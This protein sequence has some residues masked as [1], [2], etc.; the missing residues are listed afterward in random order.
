M[1]IQTVHKYIHYLV[2]PI[3][4]IISC[5]STKKLSKNLCSID[6]ENN[7][8]SGT[9]LNAKSFYED[10]LFL[11]AIIE[12]LTKGK[13]EPKYVEKKQFSS[14][15]LTKYAGYHIY[16]CPDTTWAKQTMVKHLIEKYHI[17]KYD[18]VY[19]DTVHRIKLFD[20]SIVKKRSI[21]DCAY[22]DIRVNRRVNEAHYISLKCYSWSRICKYILQEAGKNMDT[23]SI[24]CDTINTYC[25]FVIPVEAY[26]VGGLEGY[27]QHL[28]DS[29]GISMT[30]ERV[31]TINLSVYD[32]IG[33]PN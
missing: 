15:T 9:D 28:L 21:E 32:Y 10:V 12:Q 23:N 30:L 6:Y 27:K 25:D 14:K 17:L 11:P 3:L 24:V 18:S 20:K 5:T 4:L 13:F 7:I 16:G 26:R 22:S 8:I 33:P 2:I 31:D 1:I 29:F 19:F